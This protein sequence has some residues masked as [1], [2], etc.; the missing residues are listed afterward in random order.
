MLETVYFCGTED[1]WVTLE[2]ASSN[3]SLTATQILFYRETQPETGG[4][5]WHYAD[6]V[7][8]PW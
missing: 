7:P 6:G 1:D 3:A 4:S 2:S 8:Q 5:F